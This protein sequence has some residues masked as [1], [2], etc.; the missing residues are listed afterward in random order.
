MFSV[1]IPLYNK[2]PYIEKAINSVLSQSFQDFELIVVD[3]GS[4][5]D[6]LKKVQ[7]FKSSKIQIIEQ[8]NAGVSTARNNGVKAAKYNY[9]AFLDADDWWDKDFLQEIK[10]LIEE[11]PEAAM[12]ASSYY[13]V[14]NGNNRVAPIALPENFKTGYIDYIKTYSQRLCMPVTSITAVLKKSAF[15]ETGGFKPQLKLGEDFDVWLRIALKH[16]VAF[17]NKQ[18]AYYN[19]DV[20]VQNRATVNLQKPQDNMLWHLDDFEKEAKRVDY[21]KQL[22]DNLR[23]YS[24]LPY[25]LEK[26]YRDI[27]QIELNKVDWTRQPKATVRQYKTPVC[28]LKIRRTI[29]KIGSRCKTFFKTI[30]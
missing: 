18:L 8:E 17:I 1:I 6:G 20:D 10:K 29:M 26:K 3:D 28:L 13:I 16:K 19:Q 2:A 24:L 21:L 25:Y 27:A 11:C 7:E 12:Y 4:K 30:N 23:V 22:L 15:E 14:K 5:D 9:I